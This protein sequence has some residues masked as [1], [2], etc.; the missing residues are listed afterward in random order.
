MQLPYFLSI[1]ILTQ[2]LTPDIMVMG[3]SVAIDDEVSLRW[4]GDN[5]LMG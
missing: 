5:I 1:F 3:C 2:A 4:G